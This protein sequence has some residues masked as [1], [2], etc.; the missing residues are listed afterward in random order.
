MRWIFFLKLCIDLFDV[1]LWSDHWIYRN[2]HNNLFDVR[3]V[4]CWL[5]F[6]LK[7]LSTDVYII[8]RCFYVIFI[9]RSFWR[10]PR[11]GRHEHHGVLQRL[12]CG[13]RL[14][15]QRQDARPVSGYLAVF[16]FLQRKD[17][18]PVSRYKVTCLN[19]FFCWFSHIFFFWFEYINKLNS[20]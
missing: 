2:L 1:I 15:L 14:F 8:Y 10:G 11:G 18:G 4:D 20:E 16:F 6:H 3:F 13:G 12:I 17:S 19:I 7:C 9:P 5:N